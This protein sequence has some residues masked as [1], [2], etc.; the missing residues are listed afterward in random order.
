[1]NALLIVLAAAGLLLTGCV[2]Q[3]QGAPVA[4][5]VPTVSATAAPLPTPTAA[6]TIA[7]TAMPAPEFFG[8]T[9]VPEFVKMTFNEFLADCSRPALVEGVLNSQQVRVDMKDYNVYEIGNRNGVAITLD[10]IGSAQKPK[11]LDATGSTLFK[12]YGRPFRHAPFAYAQND[13]WL[14]V[15]KIENTEQVYPFPE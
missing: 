8:A 13:C 3:A 5:A 1:M 12:F 4:T 15:E 11:G 2:N 14:K 10:G 9:P 7:P 6:P